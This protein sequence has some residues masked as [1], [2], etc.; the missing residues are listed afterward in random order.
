[1]VSSLL[2]ADE[3]RWGMMILGSLF[4]VVSRPRK[5]VLV[6]RSLLLNQL[7]NKPGSSRRVPLNLRDR[8]QANHREAMLRSR[9][10]TTCISP[11]SST[12]RLTARDTGWGSTRTDTRN[13]NLRC[14]SLQTRLPHLLRTPRGRPLSSLSRTRTHRACMASSTLHQHMMMHMGI[15]TSSVRNTARESPAFLQTITESLC[16][17]ARASR[18]S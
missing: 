17:A 2:S 9:T 15:T 13:S 8:V 14:S 11:V 7:S 10:S 5:Q 3:T 18:A 12:A 16:T 4:P 1:M 6:C